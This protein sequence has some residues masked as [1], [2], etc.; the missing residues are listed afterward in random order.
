MSPPGPAPAPS[1]VSTTG[2]DALAG[3]QL[4]RVSNAAR[5]AL[6]DRGDGMVSAQKV[7]RLVRRFDKAL[8]RTHLS[9]DAFLDLEPQRRRAAMND[10]DLLRVIAYCDP[11]GEDAVNRVLRQRGY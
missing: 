6:I 2:R 8:R 7:H 5:K 11:V 9:F 4:E 1:G 10:P 3:S